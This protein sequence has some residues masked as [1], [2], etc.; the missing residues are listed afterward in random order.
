MSAFNQSPMTWVDVARC[1]AA[2]TLTQSSLPSSL[3]RARVGWY[4]LE[5]ETTNQLDTAEITRWLENLFPSR[6]LLDPLRLRLEGPLHCSELPVTFEES[7]DEPMFR[8]SFG[9]I[10]GV[11]E[12]KHPHKIP[13]TPRPLPVVAALSVKGGTGR[14][15]TAITL[16]L[17]WAETSNK[18]VLLVDGDLEAPGISYL[19]EEQAGTPK[20]SLE[21]VISL[22]HSEN[23]ED[24]SATIAFTAE[25]LRDHAI[26]GNL[27]VLPLRRNLDELASSS[28]K[29]EHLSTQSR[30]Y[31]LA[32]ILSQIAAKLGC[33]GVVID[34]RAGL[35]PLGVNLALDPNVA[36]VIVTTLSDQSIRATSGLVKFIS[37]EIRRSAGT[38]RKPLLVINRV[39]AIFKQTG[40]DKKLIEPLVND[41][42]ATLVPNNGQLIKS[43]EDVFSSDLD[44]EP[45]IQVEAPE[46]LDI[47]VSSGEW[48]NYVNQLSG[49]GFPKIIGAG[50]DQWLS[51]E[52]AGEYLRGSQTE[53]LHINATY[54]NII[55]ARAQLK[56]YA[57]QLI[58][59]EN[60]EGQVPKPLVTAP[61]LALTQRFQS[62]V[63][64]AVIEGAKGTGKT[65]AARYFV[66]QKNWSSAVSGLIDLSNA[67]S[68]ELIP[69]CASIQSS[70]KFQTEADSAR[71]S[72]AVALNLDAPQ[73]IYATTTWLKTQFACGH[74]EQQWVNLWLDVIAWSSGHQSGIPGA[75]E[76]FLELLRTTE[77]SAVAIIEGLEELYS[78]STETGV[79]AAMKAALVSLPQR[80]RSEA[81]RP[82]GVLIFA[83]RDTVEAAITQNL[84][85]FRREYSSFAL[86][87]TEED[88]LELAAW[89]T[90]QSGVLPD[91]WSPGFKEQPSTQKT[92][93]LA[94]LWGSKLGP[95]DVPGKR[96]REAYTSSWI[97]AVLSDLRGRLVPRDL[98]R[99]IAYAAG[100]SPDDAAENATYADRLLIPQAL[101][102]AVEPTSRK[103]VEEA[104]EEISEL[105]IAFE[106]FKEK[107]DQ[108]AAPLTT[109]AIAALGLTDSEI[110]TLIK[111][112]IVFGDGAPYEVPE[113]YRRG[114]G[115]LHTGAR[116]S[117][118]NLYK[119]ARRAS[120]I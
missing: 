52:V 76:T 97:I 75:G 22:A 54:S 3:I 50:I 59:A 30:P 39:P 26:S 72:T 32:D 36:P 69:V 41:L 89:L 19:F 110:K 117:V 105:K 99:F 82:L 14:T 46:L 42:L 43:S 118:V 88:V 56:K 66:A 80:L 17:R 53:P 78:S 74:T 61:L 24:A 98:V 7:T 11:I 95:N 62:E 100:Y 114:L 77:K 6:V 63:P 20:I 93:S 4:G 96:T 48:N 44:L 73:K 85:Q 16:A 21:D 18:P 37:N 111:H 70:A 104:E 13:S 12:F 108:I 29:T 33:A 65:L 60:T 31:A 9:T 15:T 87:W 115:L 47:Q 55:D 8:Q 28:I 58:A 116:R 94:Q 83:R 109:E 51:T 68:A 86:S 91:L 40:M 45:F 25:R 71:E 2:I 1:F 119:K 79:H 101:R 102:T 67:V 35:V 5:F 90:S 64:I 23:S 112:G 103:K 10:D 120:V 107:A 113:L 49:S 81:R 38:P 106:K 34:V 92:K 57:D 27:V 84:D